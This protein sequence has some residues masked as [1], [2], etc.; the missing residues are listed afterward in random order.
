MTTSGCARGEEEEEER[1]SALLIVL[2]LIAGVHCHV[3]LALGIVQYF[4]LDGR[5]TTYPG[6]TNLQLG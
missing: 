5:C 3:L 1:G 6:G 2:I 4:V